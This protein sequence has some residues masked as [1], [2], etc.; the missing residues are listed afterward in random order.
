MLGASGRQRAAGRPPPPTFTPRLP[1]PGC[2][3]VRAGNDTDLL[4]KGGACR[5]GQDLA[6]VCGASCTSLFQRKGREGERRKLTQAVPCRCLLVSSAA[7]HTCKGW[8][9][10][11]IYFY[12]LHAKKK[13]LRGGGGGGGKRRAFCAINRLQKVAVPRGREEDGAAGGGGVRRG[14]AQRLRILR[15]AGPGAGQSAWRLV[16]A[17][18]R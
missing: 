11:S 8:P 12:S 4:C 17:A 1:G 7:P 6:A 15:R 13:G 16:P 9:I 14:G 2:A 18:E 5:A 10:N 3:C